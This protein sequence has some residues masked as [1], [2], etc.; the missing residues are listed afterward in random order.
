MT[1]GE[2]I[3]LQRKRI[4]I[5]QEELSDRLGFSAKTIQRWEA[6]ERMPNTKVLP[7]LAEA[8][9]TSVEYLMGLTE[10]EPQEQ[11]QKNLP[12]NNSGI[13]NKIPNETPEYLDL[14]YWGNVAENAERAARSSDNGKKAAVLM[15]LRM[16]TDAIT[17]AGDKQTGGNFIA[18]QENHQHVGDNYVKG[19]G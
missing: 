14:G 11:P 9:N 4:N 7:K 10:S 5:K 3:R 19:G 12:V 2:R 15:M 16:A 8:L 13:E 18:V 6:G 17:G 1:I